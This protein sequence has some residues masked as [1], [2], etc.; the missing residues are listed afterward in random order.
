MIDLI[1][2]IYE[3]QRKADEIN[4]VQ[5]KRNFER[6]F[7][8]LEEMGYHIQ[9]PLNKK[10]NENDTSMEGMLLNSNSDVIKK[11]IKPIIYKKEG[12]SVMLIQKGI[13]I[14]E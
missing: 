9:I 5:F 4:A 6:I 1:N 3:I 8:E 13:V 2:Q 10:Y 12:D 7:V 14:V 11:V